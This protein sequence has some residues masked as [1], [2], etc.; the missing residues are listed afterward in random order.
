[1]SRTKGA[2]S[3]QLKLPDSYSL[4]P[5]QSLKMIADLLI[6]I[7]CEEGLCNLQ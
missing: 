5:E 3:K 4:T 2:T 1:M 6:E 7:I